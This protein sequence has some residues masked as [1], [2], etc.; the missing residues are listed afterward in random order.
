MNDIPRDMKD[1]EANLL[2]TVQMGNE[3]NVQLLK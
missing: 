2:E 1:N 3:K